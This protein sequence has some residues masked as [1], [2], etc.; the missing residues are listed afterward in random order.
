MS[1]TGSAYRGCNCY[2]GRR[3]EANCGAVIDARSP[4][5]LDRVLLEKAPLYRFAES[6]FDVVEVAVHGGRLLSG[7]QPIAPPALDDE[8]SDFDKLVVG[9]FCESFA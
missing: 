9:K 7:F 8:R 2:V 4:N 1:A 6:Q 5:L 3:W